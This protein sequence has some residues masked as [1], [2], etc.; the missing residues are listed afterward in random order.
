VTGSTSPTDDK[1]DILYRLLHAIN[2]VLYK[3][4]IYN[5]F[6]CP[7]TQFSCPSTETKI[8]DDMY[9]KLVRPTRLLFTSDSNYATNCHNSKTNLFQLAS[10]FSQDLQKECERVLDQS[11]SSSSASS[12]FLLCFL[13]LS[14]CLL[15]WSSRS[16]MESLC[17]SISSSW[18]CALSSFSLLSF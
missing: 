16:L 13:I 14:L 6:F 5:L 3:H 10:Q 4:C 11:E 2:N 1:R 9:S 8:V 15:I 18:C 7:L 12:N 17:S